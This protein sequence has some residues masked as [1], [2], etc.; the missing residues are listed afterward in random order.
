[1]GDHKKRPEPGESIVTICL[2]GSV[3]IS[4]SPPENSEVQLVTIYHKSRDL[5]ALTGECHQA[6]KHGTCAAL[7]DKVEGENME[8][9]RRTALIFRC[10]KPPSITSE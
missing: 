10:V 1:M 9:S 7:T 5:L 6:W 8:Q 4:F 2:G 3:P